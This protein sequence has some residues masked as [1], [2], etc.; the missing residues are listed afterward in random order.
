MRPKRG[1]KK[2]EAEATTFAPV[3]SDGVRASLLRAG[4]GVLTSAEAD[5]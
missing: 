3:D 4:A 2:T 1:E 5:L